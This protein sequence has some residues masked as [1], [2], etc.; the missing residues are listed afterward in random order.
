MKHLCL[1]YL[2]E[3][4]WEINIEYQILNL[5]QLEVKSLFI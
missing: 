5:R 4:V 3:L 1:L 2:R